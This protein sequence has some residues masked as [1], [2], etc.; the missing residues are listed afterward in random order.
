M[1][2]EATWVST[3]SAFLTSVSALAIVTGRYVAGVIILV[4]FA[5]PLARNGTRQ[6][7]RARQEE[8]YSETGHGGRAPE[9][10]NGGPPHHD[11]T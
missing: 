4:I 3:A 9:R 5:L 10:Q 1:K 6:L 11:E 2:R 8:S 7:K